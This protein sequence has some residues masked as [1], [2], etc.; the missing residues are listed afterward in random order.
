MLKTLRR[1]NRLTYF[2]TK[3]NSAINDVDKMSTFQLVY[4]FDI[5]S[6]RGLFRTKFLIILFKLDFLLD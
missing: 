3:R 6:S 4:G 2:Q 5:L 1:K